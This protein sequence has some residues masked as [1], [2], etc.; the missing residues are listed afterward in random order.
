ME[1][2]WIDE[3]RESA[4]LIAQKRLQDAYI[5]EME[6]HGATAYHR[7]LKFCHNYTTQMR[8]AVSTEAPRCANNDFF[9]SPSGLPYTQPIMLAVA[10]NDLIPQ[11]SSYTVTTTA[12]SRVAKN[13][14]LNVKIMK[15]RRR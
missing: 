3:A 15:V 13:Q 1:Q 4:S 6:D 5:P 7:L 9:Q 2:D 12:K 11:I 10:M 8:S 14:K